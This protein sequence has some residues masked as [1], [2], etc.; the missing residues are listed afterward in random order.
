MMKST[1]VA[2][3]K[4]GKVVRLDQDGRILWVVCKDYDDSMPEEQKWSSGIYFDS[5]AKAVWYADDME[6]MFLLVIRDDEFLANPA[7]FVVRTR[8]EAY[9]KIEEYMAEHGMDEAVDWTKLKE[10]DYVK[11]GMYGYMQIENYNMGDELTLNDDY[12]E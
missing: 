11:Y 4:G 10:N 3:L 2:S 8:E 7:G 12:D 6:E 9:R 5:L 1:L